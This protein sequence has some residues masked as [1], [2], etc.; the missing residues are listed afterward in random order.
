MS[1][2]QKKRRPTVDEAD[3][4]KAP[5]RPRVLSPDLDKRHQLRCSSRD[6][7]SWVERSQ[8]LGFP[9]V[10]SWIRKVINDELKRATR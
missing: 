3:G 6:L 5:G 2:A 8:A 9:N 7:D 10:S 4:G 1:M